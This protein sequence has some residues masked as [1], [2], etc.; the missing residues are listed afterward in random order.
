MLYFL[1]LPLNLV[2]SSHE[3]CNVD[4][5]PIFIVPL[6]FMSNDVYASLFTC[7]SSFACG[8]VSW[9]TEDV[10]YARVEPR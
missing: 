6:F 4:A 1:Q 7:F 5:R 9:S 3:M 10:R 8:T 2:E